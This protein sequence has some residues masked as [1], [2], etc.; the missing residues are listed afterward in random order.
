[1]SNII[2]QINELLNN[3][4]YELP[5]IHV[6]GVLHNVL[7]ELKALNQL[8]DDLKSECERLLEDNKNL[9][10]DLRNAEFQLNDCRSIVDELKERE[11]HCIEIELEAKYANRY[12]NKLEKIIVQLVRNTQYR[13]TITTEEQ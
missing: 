13:Q 2:E 1:M 4:N 12:V 11:K 6:D 3:N 5:Y 8:N 9:T 7:E 10:S